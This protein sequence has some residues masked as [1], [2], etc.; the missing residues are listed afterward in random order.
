MKPIL[1]IIFIWMCTLSTFAQTREELK[2]A[3]RKK[4]NKLFAEN[5]D[6]GRFPDTN[7]LVLF[8]IKVKVNN[9]RNSPVVKSIELSDS[10]Q[11]FYFKD[12]SFL[13]TINYN[14]LTNRVGKDLT[15]VFPILIS[16]V[17]PKNP[18]VNCATVTAYN[19]IRNFMFLKDYYS[20]DIE[21][22]IYTPG[23]I[24][25]ALQEELY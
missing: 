4:I 11:I 12:Y 9:E 1:S 10:L 18:C 23:Y 17:Q 14:L 25:L 16:I 20:S 19:S 24:T 5:L 3:E 8:A 22:Y 2:L 6:R 13:R 21:D 7:Q 15:F